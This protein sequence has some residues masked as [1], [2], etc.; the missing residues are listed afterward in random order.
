ML[1][2]ILLGIDTKVKELESELLACDWDQKALSRGRV[3]TKRAR[4]NLVFGDKAQEPR[5]QEGKG[6]I[7][8]FETLPLL[9]YLRN[10]CIGLVAYAQSVKPKKLYAEGNLYF[11]NKAGIGFHGDRE[12]NLVIGIRL[13]GAF[14]LVFQWYHQCKRLG[15]RMEFNLNDGDIYLMSGKAVGSDWR[16]SSKFTLRHAAGAAKYTS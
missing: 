12:R 9:A 6:R 8:A 10:W 1:Q 16:K 2:K 7:I 11:H 15:K 14:P 13:G 3:V 5:V 4:Y